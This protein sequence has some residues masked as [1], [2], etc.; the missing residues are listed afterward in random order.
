[1]LKTMESS[2]PSPSER[3]TNAQRLKRCRPW[4]KIDFDARIN[5]FT[6]QL[7]FAKPAVIS[8]AVCASFGFINTQTDILQ[9]PLCHIILKC[10]IPKSLD[11]R[12]SSSFSDLKS[13]IHFRLAD[14]ANELATRFSER[15]AT[16]HS[17]Y[18]P[19]N[20]NSVLLCS[21]TEAK[22]D[23]LSV[24]PPPGRPISGAAN[25]ARLIASALPSLYT[26]FTPK[27]VPKIK[28]I[29]PVALEHFAH[30]RPSSISSPTPHLSLDQ[31]NLPR[32][33]L[34]Q[35]FLDEFVRAL[36]STLFRFP[37]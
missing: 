32:N 7:W 19:W 12:Q 5:T 36:S 16:S 4:D 25:A 30:S 9:C 27:R 24:F 2:T 21:P 28:S 11:S 37:F 33:F 35:T 31:T 18:C 29:S 15:L 20:G 14:T 26:D 13:S 23:A 8:P 1:M 10:E 22:D 6:R 17:Q 3:E 34:S